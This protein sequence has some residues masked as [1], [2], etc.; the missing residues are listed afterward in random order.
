MTTAADLAKY[1]P[2]QPREPAGG[3]GGGEWTS[4]GGGSGGD[5]AAAMAGMKPAEV[6]AYVTD[7]TG[8]TVSLAR[9]DNYGKPLPDIRVKAND[10]RA[11]MTEFIRLHEAFPQV[12]I[13][14]I[15]FEPLKG[16][17]TDPSLRAQATTITDVW[18][19][20]ADIRLAT[21][22]WRSGGYDLSGRFNM[23]FVAVP[24][25]EG[26]MAHEFGHAVDNAAQY[27]SRNETVYPNTALGWRNGAFYSAPAISGYGASDP[28][29]KFA[30][31]FSAVYAPPTS[32][33]D[34]VT[35]RAPVP[36]EQAVALK[37]YLDAAFGSSKILKYSPD[38]P[39]DEAGRWTS[40]GGGYDVAGTTAG[41]SDPSSQTLPASWTD[42]RS[43]IADLSARYPNT[44]FSPTLAKGDPARTL[45]ALARLDY[46]F[47]KFPGVGV[48]KVGMVAAPFRGY[49]SAMAVTEGSPAGAGS[50]IT[51]N[52]DFFGHDA[53]PIGGTPGWLVDGTDNP[54]GI[55]TH[56]FGHAVMFQLWGE[57][58]DVPDSPMMSIQ[59]AIR[60]DAHTGFGALSTLSGYARA[61]GAQEAFAEAFAAAYNPDSKE[62]SNPLAQAITRLIAAEPALTTAPSD[63]AFW[64][65]LRTEGLAPPKLEKAGPLSFASRAAK[66][67]R[68]AYVAAYAAGIQAAA[69]AAA[70]A[71]ADTSID[72]TDIGVDPADEEAQAEAEALGY[73]DVPADPND[74]NAEE[75]DEGEGDTGALTDVDED[76]AD[77]NAS[78]EDIGYVNDLVSKQHDRLLELSALLIGGAASVAQLD[79]WLGQYAVSA[80][81]V[82]EA[83]FGNGA[84]Q[85]GEI[86]QATWHT[87]ED[88]V[89]CELCDGRDG[90]VW[91]GDDPHPYPGEGGYGEVCDGGPNCRCE[92]WYDIVPVDVF[93]VGGPDGGGATD[94]SLG[95]LE[96]TTADA[97][98]IAGGLGSEHTLDELV[99]PAAEPDYGVLADEADYD[100]ADE[101]YNP[102]GDTYA[103][104]A[105]VPD[106]TILSV[107]DLTR[108][109][110]VAR[111]DAATLTVAELASLRA[112]LKYSPDQPRDD[113][114][115]WTS[116]GG[117]DPAAGLS[118]HDLIHG[119]WSGSSEAHAIRAGLAQ[120]GRSE[121]RLIGEKLLAAANTA[122]PTTYPLY[123]GIALSKAD[124]ARFG[125]TF[126][127]GARIDLNL[128]SWTRGENVARDFASNAWGT[129]RRD[130]AT[131][132]GMPFHQVIFDC[133]PGARAY[134]ATYDIGQGPKY[135]EHLMAGR[136]AVAGVDHVD[137]QVVEGLTT[138]VV[139]M[140]QIGTLD[141]PQ[142]VGTKVAAVGPARLIEWLEPYLDA[143]MVPS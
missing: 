81:P 90:Q 72:P 84:A 120:G 79:A 129:V 86:T 104:E 76:L 62:S 134:D 4:D 21:E 31:L 135:T 43:A 98:G 94:P 23:G 14:K 55:V 140:S 3:P 36:P 103:E 15:T 19:G 53:L 80:N 112:L 124:Y 57:H 122:P 117:A 33:P 83:G 77:W 71:P 132:D 67:I 26:L 91:I 35:G 138:D 113:A 89:V 39:R 46:L 16:R 12:R 50:A 7:R 97:A 65:R 28:T 25:P 143:R 88:G 123:R 52:P 60:N 56:E 130:A 75:P 95:P 13:G 48:S 116:D 59:A 69:A 87:Q 107:V 121:G 8:T 45:P 1:S 10:F 93:D 2:D 58:H 5:P 38:Q 136:F 139:H 102:S 51:L 17:F 105:A 100:P 106:L 68:A 141:A 49:R 32:L 142:L 66:A 20:T 131:R 42:V 119:V 125:E 44:T 137:S 54:A 40:D 41:A 29:E 133:T 22:F 110:V 63:T 78:Y 18:H 9:T 118:T 34:V 30:E 24:G 47:G 109:R 37:A 73:Q 128:A 101:L 27:A 96:T 11:A 126:H 92:L 99:P 111:G 61:A 74:P 115:R 82:Y 85:Q 6:A 70:A 108:L 127:P 114:G 64:D